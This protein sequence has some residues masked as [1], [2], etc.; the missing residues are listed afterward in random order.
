MH[1]VG[2][3]AVISRMISRVYCAEPTIFVCVI[4]FVAHLGN[5]AVLRADL[6][7]GRAAALVILVGDA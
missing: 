6:P 3:K 4:A 2:I 1:V 5:S 7:S